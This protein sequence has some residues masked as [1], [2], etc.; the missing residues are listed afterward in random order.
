[1]VG[2]AGEM[3]TLPVAE[4]APLARATGQRWL[5]DAAIDLLGPEWDQRRIAYYAG[6]CG[7]D[8]QGDFIGLRKSIRKFDDL[9]RELSTSARRRELRAREATERD[10]DAAAR[11]SFFTAAILYGAAQ[12]SI[13]ENT[14]FNLLLE[15]KKT[16]C[17][18]AFVPLAGRRV[19]RIEVPF[20]DGSAPA[21]LHFPP[22]HDGSPL[23]CVLFVSGMDGFKEFSVAMDGDR[24][25]TR[26]FAV[27]AV[28]G[29][30]QGECLTRGVWYEP[31][32]Y[33]EFATPAYELLANRPEIDA[34]RIF[35]HGISFGS[36]WVTQ[37][38]AAEP[39]FA[40]C[41][42]VMT[43][44]EPGAFSTFET[45][46]PTFR[47][48]FSYMVNAKDDAEVDR[49]RRRITTHGLSE[50]IACPYLIVGGEDDQLSD[51]GDTVDHMNRVT[52]PKTLIIYQGED[53]G[54]HSA[55]SG[56]LGPEAFSTAADWLQDR[57]RGKN[58]ASSFSVVDMT[59]KVTRRPY[60]ADLVYDYGA[61]LGLEVFA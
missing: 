17:Y 60:E 26:G 50:R 29:P 6:A 28:D 2:V 55:R 59:G 7:S 49:V 58:E 52:A 39:R 56:Q 1:M 3:P 22:G 53:H 48:R 45:A 51:I 14:P 19:E 54:L 16:E 23:P 15:R 61:P 38:A 40:G 34:Q 57:A 35:L 37:L 13:F 5:L 31:E 11:E 20:A 42:A 25:L 44:F 27:L 46:S 4:L 30:G 9:A 8:C 18:Q 10:H 47:T 24:Y 41:S 12:W 36:F 43:C 32:R 21:Y 33:G